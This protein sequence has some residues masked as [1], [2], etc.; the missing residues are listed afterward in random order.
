M[1]MTMW[2]RNLFGDS[3]VLGVQGSWVEH[4]FNQLVT[5]VFQRICEANPGWKCVGLQLLR[6]VL[7]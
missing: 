4:D 5:A 1:S 2:V 3:N 6:P 7:H